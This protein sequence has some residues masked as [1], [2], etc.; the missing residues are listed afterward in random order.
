MYM[1]R[2]IWFIPI[3][4]STYDL[5]GSYDVLNEHKI[6]VGSGNSSNPGNS[7]SY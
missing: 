7:I 5:N 6:N 4:I 2:I 1:S 3:N